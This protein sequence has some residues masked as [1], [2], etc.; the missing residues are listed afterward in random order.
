MLTQKRFPRS[1]VFLIST[2]ALVAYSHGEQ[3]NSG[4]TFGWLNIQTV[5]V[6]ADGDS[7][8]SPGIIVRISS[9][10]NNVQSFGFSNE[11]GVLIMPLPPGNYCY[12]AYSQNGATLQL[13]RQG[14]SRCFV[15]KK[16]G[17]T[18]VGI[19]YLK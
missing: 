4:L 7:H 11:A 6:S 19:E 2:M 1:I 9:Q 14:D 12:D 10:D 16:D 8:M 3:G 5:V 18:E 17:V 15:M 13:R